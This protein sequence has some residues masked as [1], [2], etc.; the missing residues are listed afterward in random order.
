MVKYGAR[1]NGI[2][3]KGIRAK[4]A[5]DFIFFKSIP[6]LIAFF[7]NNPTALTF[8]VKRAVERNISIPGSHIMQL[9][10]MVGVDTLSV[11][12]SSG[13]Q[14]VTSLSNK[15]HINPK[16]FAETDRIISTAC[17]RFSV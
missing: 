8:Y 15:Q 6:E 14:T 2:K 17:R 1:P 5:D 12:G 13:S 11:E 7:D 16:R 4:D 9:A 10:K 3:T